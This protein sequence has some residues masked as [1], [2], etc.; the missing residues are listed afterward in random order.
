M[1]TRAKHAKQVSCKQ[2]PY[3][4]PSGEVKPMWLALDS[5]GRGFLDDTEEGAEKML[6]VFNHPPK[7]HT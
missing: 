5:T 3:T 7:E 6:A 2:V 4:F 1:A